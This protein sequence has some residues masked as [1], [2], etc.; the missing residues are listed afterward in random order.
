[1]ISI[2]QTLLDLDLFDKTFKYNIC[3]LKYIKFIKA[4]DSRLLIQNMLNLLMIRNLFYM[5]II[6]FI[7]TL[8]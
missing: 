3:V 5:K 7:V 1:M 2:I 4:F 8:T 6:N